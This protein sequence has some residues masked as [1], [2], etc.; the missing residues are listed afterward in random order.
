MSSDSYKSFRPTNRTLSKSQHHYVSFNLGYSIMCFLDPCQNGNIIM[1]NLGITCVSFEPVSFYSVF[2]SF[3]STILRLLSITIK[4]IE[5]WTFNKIPTEWLNC[6]KSITE[7]Y[8]PVRFY[9]PKDNNR[10]T[11][12]MDEICSKLII[13]APERRQW[14]HSGVFIVDFEQI[15]HIILV[16]LLLTLVNADWEDVHRGPI[17]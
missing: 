14:R 13:K 15:L 9:L 11:K 1:L 8:N 2:V 12:T 7:C 5:L 10:N 6:C 17:K 4:W 3:Q 16:F